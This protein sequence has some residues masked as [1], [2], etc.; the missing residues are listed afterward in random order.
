MSRTPTDRARAE[1]TWR[2]VVAGAVAFVTIAG[3]GACSGA[4]DGGPSSS[5]MNTVTL[6]PTE[7]P[8]IRVA[9]VGDSNTTG[10][11]GTLDNGVATGQSWVAQLQKPR[12]DVVG[13]WARDGASTA[14]MAQQVTPLPDIDVLVFM[15]GTNDPPQGISGTGT[16]ENLRRIVEVVHP[17]H[18]VVSSVPPVQAL[19]GRAVLLNNELRESALRSHWEYADPWAALR[20]S[21]AK[22]VHPYLRDGIHTTPAGY[23]VVGEALRSVIADAAERG[24]ASY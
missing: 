20:T 23:A 5:P 15:G 21:E 10:L 11:G 8:S 3:L 18:V 13:G 12:F 4:F 1:T 24:G 9:V 17:Q 6:T 22:W 19:P 14:L 16:I 2:T 7:P